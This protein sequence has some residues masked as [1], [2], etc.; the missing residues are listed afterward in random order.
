[1]K[2][3]MGIDWDSKTLKCY[4]GFLGEKPKKL[5][6]KEPSLQA[7]KQKISWLKL[8][9]PQVTEIHAMIESGSEQWV[10]LLHENGI[11]VHVSNAKLAKCFQ[12]SLCASMAKDDYRD[13][14]A[15]LAML[16]SPA[17]Q[18][19]PWQ[20]PSIIKQKVERLAKLHDQAT[21][22]FTKTKQRFRAYLRTNMPIIEAMIDDVGAK[23]VF[24]FFQTISSL[25]KL[26]K[27]SKSR[28]EK[29]MSKTRLSAKNKE[30]LWHA[31]ERS[32]FPWASKELED[33]E[34]FQMKQWLAQIKQHKTYLKELRS[35]IDTLL[36]SIPIA[37]SL[38]NIKG[39]GSSLSLLLLYCGGLKTPSH[40]DEWSRKTGASPIFIGSGTNR[41]G[42]AKGYVSMRRSV[43]S[44]A[45]QLTYM[46]GLN[47]MKNC[48]WARAM[49]PGRAR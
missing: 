24:S 45:K 16:Q 49:F 9:Y 3:Y 11:I 14:M 25:W 41:K 29:L 30:K 42:E 31:I 43:S 40:R 44:M 15:L 37:K 19:E 20:P 46:L 34:S 2:L 10:P 4:Y 33:L 13:A 22:S 28:F 36:S 32:R 21:K 7:V 5:V 39:I 17:H 8:N 27:L 6:F 18:K 47:L 48:V 23:W 35:R 38:Q 26:K 1:M 12:R